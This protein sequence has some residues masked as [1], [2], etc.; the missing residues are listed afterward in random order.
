[1]S[2]TTYERRIVKTSTIPGQL[3][4]IPVSS[5]HRNGDW[6]PTDIYKGEWFFNSADG[7]MYTRGENGIVP[8]VGSGETHGNLVFV[9]DLSKLPEPVSGVITLLDGYS[10]LFTLP[11]DLLGSRIVSGENSVIVGLSSENCSITSTELDSATALITSEYTMPMRFISIKDVGT[12]LD[13]DGTTNTVELDWTGVNFKNV[14]TIGVIDNCSNFIFNKGAFLTAKGLRFTGTIGTIALENS[15]FIGDGGEGSII[16]LDSGLTATRRFRMDKSSIIAFGGDVGIL[17]DEGATIPDESFILDNI[18]FSGGGT[19][20]SG[21]DA[22][23]NT[24]LI[25]R[26]NGIENSS[27]IGYYYMQDNAT[28]TT[29]AS[30]DTPVKIA[31]ETIQGS[32]NSKFDS[33]TVDNRSTYQ[34]A[35]DDTFKVDV[36]LSC[37]GNNNTDFSFYVYKNGTL[38]EGSKSS[39]TTDGTGSSD[40]VK[41]QGLASTSPDDYFEVWA[42][43]NAGSGNITVTDMSVIIPKI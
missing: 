25:S 20:L 2:C 34:G 30:N 23:S 28:A 16:E 24:A 4:T 42:E 22:T 14:N 32:V 12:A 9:D 6:L 38:L 41:L 29:I 8:I 3:P 40:N 36:V 33:E 26:C 10:Y 31:G 43:R 15:I 17:V 21:I 18:N 27:T 39:T 19:Y 7:T 35:L 1:M 13:F 37:V 11:V 5:D